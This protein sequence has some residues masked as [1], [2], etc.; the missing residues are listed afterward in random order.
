MILLVLFYSGLSL[1]EFLESF[2]RMARERLERPWS[3]SG[4]CRSVSAKP[5]IVLLCAERG[6][7]GRDAFRVVLNRPANTKGRVSLPLHSLEILSC[8]L[9]T[10]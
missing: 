3:F 9:L 2:T 4:R 7:Y 10:D 5:A 8:F 6:R 1:V